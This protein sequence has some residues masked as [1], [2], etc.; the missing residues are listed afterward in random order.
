MV[1]NALYSSFSWMRVTTHHDHSHHLAKVNTVLNDVQTTHFSSMVQSFLHT[2]TIYGFKLRDSL[3]T[4]LWKCFPVR[5][6][7]NSIGYFERFST[8]WGV[9]NAA[10]VLEF[11]YS[12]YSSTRGCGQWRNERVNN[13]D[14]LTARPT[15]NQ[16][17][18][19][20]IY[21]F[22]SLIKMWCWTSASPIQLISSVKASKP[23]PRSCWHL[24]PEYHRLR[25]LR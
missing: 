14:Y 10:V 2:Y 12:L 25:D 5:C 4:A 19:L 6:N 3:Y 13:V 21:L 1:Y 23:G 11:T 20:C 16:S 24:G 18:N 7:S 17:I 15:I 9:R 8:Y 22:N